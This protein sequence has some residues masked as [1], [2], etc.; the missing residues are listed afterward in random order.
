L[1]EQRETW[2]VVT[3][4]ETVKRFAMA[5]FFE[6]VARDLRA[7]WRPTTMPGAATGSG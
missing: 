7:V 4:Q 6:N 1:F 2:V 5:G 3:I